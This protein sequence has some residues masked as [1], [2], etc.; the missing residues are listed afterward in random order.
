MLRSLYS[1]VSGLRN[2]QVAMDT[3]SNNIANV[4]THGFRS[5]RATFKEAMYQ[6]LQGAT[7]PP[8]DRGGRN[9]MQVGLGMQIGSID[10]ILTQGALESTG[11]IT[12]V[13]IEGDAYFAFSDGIGTYYSRNGNLQMDSSGKLVSAS[14]GFTLQGLT[15]DSNG[16]FS[17]EAIPGDIEIP[18]GQKAPASATN[19]VKF[20]SNLDKDSAGLGTILHTG[21]FLAVAEDDNLLTGLNDQNGNLLNVQ[22]GDR[23]RIDIND[24]NGSYSFEAPVGDEANEIET[25]EDLAQWLQDSIRDGADGPGIAGA[26]V[27]INADGQFEISDLGGNTLSSLSIGNATRPN[28]DTYMK[29]VFNWNSITGDDNTSSG[30][31][32][33]AASEDHDLTDV[34]DAAGQSLGLEAG[35][36]VDIAGSIGS[37]S[38]NFDPVVFGTDFTTM[39]EYLDLIQQALNLPETIINKD[40]T[41]VPTVEINRISGGDERV[42]GGSII[43]RG[44]A[45]EAFALN[46]IAINASTDSGSNISPNAFNSNMAFAEIQSARDTTEHSTSIEVYDES[47]QAHTMTTTFTHTGEPNKWLWEITMQGDQELIGGHKGTLEFGQDGSPSSWAFDDGA[48]KFQFDPKNG[49]ANVSIDLD[50]GGPGNFEGITQFSSPT[51]T[52]AKEQNGYT[53]GNLDEIAVAED[54][55]INGSFTN[56]TNQPIAK[57]LL[58]DFRNPGGLKRLGDNMYTTSNNSGEAVYGQAT[59]SSTSK[60]KPGA[61]EMSN[62]ELEKE[63]TDLI[64][65]QKGYQAN[66]RVI[67]QSDEILDELINLVR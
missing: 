41:E 67:T 13:A 37:E 58:A 34:F 26:T 27:A 42:P 10:T 51:T 32:L 38:I 64:K 63:F 45:Q 15:A 62:V 2:H 46:G 19:E 12:D 61:L 40:G 25:V 65:T 31:A 59:T 6:T 18:F 21:K 56:G 60:I 66:S 1:G 35:D 57:M 8:G 3:T 22:D 5:Q 47:G 14:N 53:M 49:S 28:S 44:Q 30:K 11:Q 36:E 4:N 48:S 9:P 39:G 43:I 52:S 24:T 33:T 16:N 50:T 55:T 20:S 29:N 54:G 23:L 7:R 17:S